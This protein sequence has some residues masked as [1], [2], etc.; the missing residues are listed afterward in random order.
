[1]PA[2]RKAK[3]SVD[4]HEHDAV[5]TSKDVDDQDGVAPV[6][7]G[8]DMLAEIKGVNPKKYMKDEEETEV[9]GSGYMVHLSDGTMN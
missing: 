1:M 6:D 3:K 8:D 4:E 9:K 5:A 2:T 7:A